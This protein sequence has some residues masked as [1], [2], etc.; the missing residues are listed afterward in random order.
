MRPVP[1]TSYPGHEVAASFSP[2]G[3]QVAFSWNGGTTE[4]FDVYVKVVGPPLRLTTHPDLDGS[5]VWS[6]DGRRIAFLRGRPEAGEKMGLYLIPALG[7][8]E[9]KLAETRVPFTY[10]LGSCL[11]WSPDSRWLAVCDRAEDSPRRLSVFLLSVDSGERRRLTWPPEDSPL[12]DV[13]PAFSPDGRDIVFSAGPMMANSSLWRVPVSGTASPERLPFGEVG[14]WPFVSRQGNRLAYTRRDMNVNIYRLNLPVADSVTGKEVRLISS[15]RWDL[16]PRYSPDVNR[17]AFTSLRSGVSAIW[18]S[19][20][21]G[22]NPV[23]LTSLGDQTGDPRWA[24]DGKSIAFGSDAEGQFD[25]YVVDA[26]GGAPRRLTSDPSG[27]MLPSWSRDGEWIYFWSNRNGLA[28]IFKMP[29]GGGPAQVVTA[30]QGRTIE[31]PDGQWFYFERG[32]NHSVWRMPVGGGGEEDAE[33]VLE[34]SHE[35]TYGVVEEG[36][37]FVPP[38]EGDDYSLQFLRFATGAV[39][40]IHDFERRPGGILSVAPDGRSILFFQMEPL[41]ADIMLV[42]NFR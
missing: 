11:A 41:E 21:D 37:Y 17:I 7:G 4:N 40:L 30:G 28:Q 16:Q 20:G 27:G 22:S 39:E 36:V 18:T 2:D 6:P 24:P 26:E 14:V 5:P 13:M 15:S 38:A 29:A 25:V 8:N 31:S 34:P 9:R 32:A 23:Q 10:L 3:N 19:A 1:L 42:E 33:Q 12:G 35:A